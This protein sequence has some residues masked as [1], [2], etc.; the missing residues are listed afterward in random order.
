M[1]HRMPGLAQIYDPNLCIGWKSGRFA[2]SNRIG[3]NN[4]VLD[5]TNET[6]LLRLSQSQA[7]IL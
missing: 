1:E 6:N 4:G 3:Y 5:Y 7:M 2:N